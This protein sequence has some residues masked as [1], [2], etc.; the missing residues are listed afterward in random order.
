[1][2]W[3]PDYITLAELKSYIRIP[4]TLD[5]TQLALAITAASRAVDKAT[6]RQFGKTAAPEARHFTPEWDRKICCWVAT[7]DDVMTVTGLEVASDNG[8]DYTYGTTLTEFDLMPLDAVVKGLPWT[9]LVTRIGATT[10]PVGGANALRVTAT[11]GWTAVPDPIKQATLLQASRILARR[12]S[13]Y[14]IAGSPSNGGSEMRLLARVDPDVE[15]VLA[16]FK[17]WWWAA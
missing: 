9:H 15:V 4:D 1:M 16:P 2:T 11:W 3:A 6:G 14:G 5:D 7:I 8:R 17:R 13:P 10:T 12:S